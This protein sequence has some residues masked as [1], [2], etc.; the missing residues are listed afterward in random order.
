MFLPSD[1]HLFRPWRSQSE[2]AFTLSGLLSSLRRNIAHINM[3]TKAAEIK[4]ATIQQEPS[5]N[6]QERI[7]TVLTRCSKASRL[8]MPNPSLYNKAKNSIQ[9]LSS[10]WYPN[11]S[12]SI[13]TF[14]IKRS[15]SSIDW[16]DDHATVSPASKSQWNH[17]YCKPIISQTSTHQ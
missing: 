7:Q 2:V 14:W 13:H 15:N 11:S 6:H 17:W 8:W 1:C 16:I 12:H 5:S 4:H 10:D 9:S 3:C